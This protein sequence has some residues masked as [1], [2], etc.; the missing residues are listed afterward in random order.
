[1][2]RTGSTKDLE[3]DPILEEL[4]EL[5]LLL[6][7]DQASGGPLEEGSKKKVLARAFSNP[8]YVVVCW[9]EVGENALDQ[10]P[11]LNERFLTLRLHL[12]GR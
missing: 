4:S 11:Y 3:A 2:S 12:F 10:G 5:A 8:F 1:M 6:G 7:N 9:G